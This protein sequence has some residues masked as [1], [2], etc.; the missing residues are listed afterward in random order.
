MGDDQVYKILEQICQNNVRSYT[1]PDKIKNYLTVD[2]F[3]SSSIFLT[4]VLDICKENFLIVLE[5]FVS[6]SQFSQFIL[7][8]ITL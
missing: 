1:F 7:G 3:L 5:I 2:K 6:L 8:I 4:L